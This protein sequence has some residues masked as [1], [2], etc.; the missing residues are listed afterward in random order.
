MHQKQSTQMAL[1]LATMPIQ[2]MTMTALQTQVMPMHLD[3][4]LHKA[5]V[6]GESDWGQNKME[7]E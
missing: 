5:Q 3:P 7:T 1:V 2:M 4:T 6:W